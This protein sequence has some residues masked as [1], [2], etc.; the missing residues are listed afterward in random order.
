[1]SRKQRSAT[2]LG[3]QSRHDDE[4]PGKAS[5]ALLA[6]QDLWVR[7]GKVV[8]LVTEGQCAEVIK[9]D[10]YGDA[11]ITAPYVREVSLGVLDSR[12]R[13]VSEDGYSSQSVWEMKEAIDTDDIAKLGAFS[14]ATLGSVGGK[15]TYYSGKAPHVGVALNLESGFNGHE[16]LEVEDEVSSLDFCG[17]LVQAEVKKT[18]MPTPTFWVPAPKGASDAVNMFDVGAG[19]EIKVVKFDLPFLFQTASAIGM[20]DGESQ[21]HAELAA[22]LVDN[23]EIACETHKVKRILIGFAG[24]ARS[25]VYTPAN[26]E[27]KQ[28]VVH[29][30]DYDQS[31]PT[32][33]LDGGGRQKLR[34]WL[35]G[36]LRPGTPPPVFRRTTF[37]SSTSSLKAACDIEEK[38]VKVGRHGVDSLF[39]TA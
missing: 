34:K 6:T 21:S 38:I 14:G 17:M 33:Q 2:S 37:K 16:Q 7:T 11:V 18:P 4:R 9:V 1:M 24:K 5:P 13:L 19:K 27:T 26:H 20:E 36:D 39:D 3:D 15:Y 30:T 10:S 12:N 23:L 31:N 32:G 35:G 22:I 28:V 29:R 25:T 8:H